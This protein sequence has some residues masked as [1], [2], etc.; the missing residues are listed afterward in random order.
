MEG[1]GERGS[2]KV[3]NIT[4]QVSISCTTQYISHERVAIVIHLHE[5]KVMRGRE[6]VGEGKCEEG[7]GKGK[8]KWGGR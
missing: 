6:G 1:F 7:G 5:Q 8:R 2:R 3:S 4:H